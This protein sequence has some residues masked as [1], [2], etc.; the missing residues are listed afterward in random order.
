MLG[1]ISARA[2]MN[3]CSDFARG[4]FVNLAETREHQASEG[5]VFDPDPILTDEIFG[6]ESF[7]TGDDARKF[8]R[9]QLVPLAKSEI[10]PPLE[11]ENTEEQVTDV[12]ATEHK[13]GIFRLGEAKAIPSS[14]AGGFAEAPSF[15]DNISPNFDFFLNSWT[16][17][18][19]LKGPPAKD[20]DYLVDWVKFYPLKTI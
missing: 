5:V 20:G 15:E 4:S 6:T 1:V 8:E 16:K 11:T 3:N 10:V 9:V 13:R 7:P 18:K 17:I 2:A 19:W 14:A 12:S